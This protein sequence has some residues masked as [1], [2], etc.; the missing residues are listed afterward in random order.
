MR[1]ESPRR[2]TRQWGVGIQDPDGAVLGLSDI[3][4]TLYLTGARSSRLAIIS[5]ITSWTA[6][7][8]IILIDPDTLIAR[9]RISAPFPSS[10]RIR[11]RRSLSTAAFLDAL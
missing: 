11:L 3:V 7:A 4:E 2:R 5:A 8:I 9:I 1:W 10:R 6:S